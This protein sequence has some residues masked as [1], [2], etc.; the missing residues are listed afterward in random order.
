MKIKKLFSL[1]FVSL[2]LSGNGHSAEEMTVKSLL[3][4][5]YKITKE[6]LVKFDRY[7]QKIFTLKKSK[8]VKICTVKIKPNLG[9]AT[10]SQCMTP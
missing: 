4:E 7:A 9:V 5:G 1:I 2:L 10:Y 6:E 8:Q 3:D